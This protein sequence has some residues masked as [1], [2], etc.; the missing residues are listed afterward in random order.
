ML[1]ISCQGLF[2]VR[3]DI[4]ACIATI[5]GI[6]GGIEAQFRGHR[7]SAKW[8]PGNGRMRDELLNETLFMSLAHARGRDRRLRRGLQAW[9]DRARPWASP[10]RTS[11]DLLRD[12]LRAPL[13]SPL[14]QPPG[15]HSSWGES[16][17]HVMCHQGAMAFFHL[18]GK[19][20]SHLA[21][22]SN[23]LSAVGHGANEPC[24]CQPKNG[25]SRC[26]NGM[27]VPIGS[28][29]RR[30]RRSMLQRPSGRNFRADRSILGST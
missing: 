8:Q 3:F 13:R 14:L 17:G 16:W 7:C 30:Y 19:P 25:S 2:S 28:P 9:T 1:G 29:W 10:N 12:A 18:P 5:A 21:E 22:V 23:S 15:S 4:S 27:F 24:C 6:A 20:G 26:R 11:N